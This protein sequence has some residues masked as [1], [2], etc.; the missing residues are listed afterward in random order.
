MA[1]S[2]AATANDALWGS[3][4]I[5]TFMSAY[6]RF[7]RT[8]QPSARA[9]G[10]PTSRRAHTSFEPLRTPGT[11]GTQ[12]ENEPTHLTGDRKFASDP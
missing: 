2:T 8:S 1:S 4:P 3:T 5:S 7:G 6:L 9:K 11:G 12:A 10:I